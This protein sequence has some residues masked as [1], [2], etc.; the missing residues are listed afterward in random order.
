MQVE[1]NVKD[2]FMPME[3]VYEALLKVGMMDEEQEQK[4]ETEDREGQYYQ[5]HKR[6]VGHP[7]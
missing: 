3:T 5:Y 4:V 2:V 7:I 1:K 6:S